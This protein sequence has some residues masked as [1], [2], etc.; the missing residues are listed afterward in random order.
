MGRPAGAFA[1]VLSERA[2]ERPAVV[3]E[4]PFGPG[5]PALELPEEP[6]AV[7]FLHNC[8]RYVCSSPAGPSLAALAAALAPGGALVVSDIFTA[9][10]ASTPWLRSSL[11]LDWAAFGALVWPRAED[12]CAQ[13]RDAGLEHA[14]LSRPDPL[15]DL[16]IAHRPS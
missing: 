15:F 11:M 14:E 12:L 6:L 2:P 10:P 7:A 4:P 9:G 3:F 13:L 5:G 8:V 1:E 16:I